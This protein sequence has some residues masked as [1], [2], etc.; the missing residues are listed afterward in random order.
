MPR[1][2][3]SPRWIAVTVFAVLVVA[4][5]VRLGFWQLDRLEGRRSAN[6]RFTTGMA[7]EPVPVESLLASGDP[8]LAFRRA[9]ADG[10]YDP[11]NEVLLYGRALDSR[12]GNHVLTPLVLA[13]GRAVLVDRGWVPFDLDTPPIAPATPPRGHVQVSGFLSPDEPGADSN[14]NAEDPGVREATTFT[15]VDLTAIGA[16]VPYDLVPWYLTLQEQSPGQ[17]HDLPAVVPPPTL[18][19]G[20]HLS[21]AFQWFA[22][23]AIAAIGYVV[24]AR[25]EVR[26]RRGTTLADRS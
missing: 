10:R 13:D 8:Q 17:S 24:L 22:F 4:L 7:I 9:T 26:D 6:D 2:L 11:S 21:Y 16:Q 23:G 19:E 3:L 20:P 14:A 15:K 5:C 12:P 1:S 18:D 25:K